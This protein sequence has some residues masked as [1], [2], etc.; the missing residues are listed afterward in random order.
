MTLKLTEEKKQNRLYKNIYLC[1]KLFEKLKT[2]IRFEIQVTANIV[3]GTLETDMIVGLS[4]H[5]QNYDPKLHYQ[6][7]HALTL[8]NGKITLK[9]IFNI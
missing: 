5:R 1:I 8:F 9:I 7:K 6:I 2:K 4:R 3:A